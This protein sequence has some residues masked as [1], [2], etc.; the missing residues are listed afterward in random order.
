MLGR[1]GTAWTGRSRIED[2][3]LPE[4]IR[5]VIGRRLGRL[6][7][8]CT[9]LLSAASVVGREFGVDALGRI[10]DLEE[11]RLL[12]VLEEAVTA[13]VVEEVPQAIGRY[14]FS[15][16]LIRETLYGELRTLERVRRHQRVAEVLEV[17]YARN[18]GP[19]LAELAHHFLETLPSGDID[20]AVDYAIRAGDR[21]QEQLA[22]EE[23]AI[24]YDRALQALELREQPDERLRCGLLLKLGEARWSAGGDERGLAESFGQAAELAERLGEPELLT[25]AALGLTGPG[26]G[27]YVVGLH[28]SSGMAGP[29]SVME[30]ALAAL[31]DRDSALRGAAGARPR[32]SAT[33]RARPSPAASARASTGSARS[34]RRSRGTS[35]TRSAPEPSA[36]AGPTAR[37]AGWSDPSGE[38]DQI[39]RANGLL[40]PTVHPPRP[41]RAGRGV[42]RCGGT[43]A[44]ARRGAPPVHG[45]GSDPNPNRLVARCGHLPQPDE[46]AH[47]LD[48]D[49][50]R[51]RAVQEHPRASRRPAR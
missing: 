10:A 50:D 40:L 31:D 34:T 14:R 24:D 48:V 6:S 3:R 44:R 45:D 33:G 47:D 15:H 29:M 9:K 2:M 27:I 16:T 18:P 37:S 46:G 36:A 35:R 13:R 5:D 7:V 32:T 4:S 51:P 28:L 22:Y 11:E 23:A 43:S 25:R 38:R 12:E 19:H 42:R 17:L 20:K 21:A 49:R 39:E 41:H 30:R 1:E 26:V 8:E